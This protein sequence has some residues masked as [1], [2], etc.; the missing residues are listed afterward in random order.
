MSD[1]SDALATPIIDVDHLSQEGSMVWFVRELIQP[2]FDAGV[3]E[4]T[5][6]E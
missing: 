1:D 3:S 6:D 5:R 4:V 2:S